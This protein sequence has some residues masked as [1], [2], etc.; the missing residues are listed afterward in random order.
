MKLS[1]LLIPLICLET[2]LL[3]QSQTKVTCGSPQLATKSLLPLYTAR[4]RCCQSRLAAISRRGSLLSGLWP[5]QAVSWAPGVFLGW[6]LANLFPSSS[7]FLG[8]YELSLEEPGGLN[9]RAPEWPHSELKYSEET[10]LSSL[11]ELGW[12]ASGYESA[13][14][15]P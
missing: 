2:S 3:S 1:S 6:K 8:T 12:G 15:L 9:I 11:D 5:T 7:P 4:P 14:Q 13:T 10:A